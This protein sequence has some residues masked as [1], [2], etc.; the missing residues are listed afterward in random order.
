MCNIVGMWCLAAGMGKEKKTMNSVPRGVLALTKFQISTRVAN[1]L[2]SDQFDNLY[3]F[4]IQTDMVISIITLKESGLNC[5][6]FFL[7]GERRH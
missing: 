6:L 4:N 3:K 7:G 1:A 5:F 2:C